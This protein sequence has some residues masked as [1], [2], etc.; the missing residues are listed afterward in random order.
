MR[1]PEPNPAARRA[2]RLLV[3]VLCSTA[4]A[5]ASAPGPGGRA[6]AAPTHGMQMVG[7]MAPYPDLEAAGR[8]NVRRARQLLRASRR[9]AH[10]FD[11]MAKARRLGYQFRRARRPGFVHLRKNGTRFWGGFLDGNTPQALVFWCPTVGRCTLT[12]YMYRAP[13]GPPPSTWHD[14]LQW[15]RHARRPT[16]TWS[17]HVW[18]VSHTR[19]G[20][21]TCA[22]MQALETDLG[23]HDEPYHAIA[24]DRPCPTDGSS[25][26]SMPG[27]DD[28]SG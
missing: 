19:E 12:T 25:G 27:M 26:G 2:R 9:T 8:R 6:I 16:V 21:A 28:A 5:A 24:V 3:A 23:I 10:R 4:A 18:L 13:G 11:T 15:H 22:P 17:T 1:R 7:N 20:F 14:L